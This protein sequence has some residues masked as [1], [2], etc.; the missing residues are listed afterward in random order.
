VQGKIGDISA[1]RVIKSTSYL[2]LG[3]VLE[4]GGQNGA[5]SGYIKSKMAA[6]RHFRKFRISNC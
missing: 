3:R 6:G 1:R 4:V 2:V 5:I